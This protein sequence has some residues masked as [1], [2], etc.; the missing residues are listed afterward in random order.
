MKPSHKLFLLQ[1]L[2]GYPESVKD[3]ATEVNLFTESLYIYIKY[4]WPCY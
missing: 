2:N 4:I 3:D 1:E